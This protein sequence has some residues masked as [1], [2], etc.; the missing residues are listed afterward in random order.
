[1]TKTN[2][3]HLIDAYGLLKAKQAELENEERSLKK[4]LG[5]LDPGAYEGE[6][7]RLS[8]SET[9]RETPDDDLK[10]KTKEIVDAFRATL[11]AQYLTA[12]TVK[13]PTRTHRV[14]ARNGDV[15]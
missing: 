7:Y 12:H 8:I 14:S 5:E 13:T 2:L 3:T 10:A 4:A 1:M 15:A 6:K 9:T 11:S